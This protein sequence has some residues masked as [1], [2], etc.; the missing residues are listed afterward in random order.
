LIADRNLPAADR[1]MAICWLFHVIGD[2]HQPCHSTAMFS[3]R[4]FSNPAEGDRGGNLVIV[5]DRFNL[6]SVWDGFPGGRVDFRTPRN[7]AIEIVND[8]ESQKLGEEAAG[9]TVPMDWLKE[10]HELAAEFV[11]APEVMTALRSLEAGTGTPE[12]A[13]LTLSE[14][15]NTQGGRVSRR[16]VVQA[17]YRL[18]AAVKALHLGASTESAPARQ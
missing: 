7:K 12:S 15:Y 14:E 6:H 5:V 1:A 8:A 16:R 9:V 17:G 2:I 4:L 13:P 11:Y 10:S 18:G 3:R